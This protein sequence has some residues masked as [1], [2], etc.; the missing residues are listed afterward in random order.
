MYRRSE[1]L[2]ISISSFDSI[3]STCDSDHMNQSPSPENH[4]IHQPKLWMALHHPNAKASAGLPLLAA[5]VT[6][7]RMAQ[8]VAWCNEET[9]SGL[10]AV[11]Q[12]A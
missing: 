11:S 8:Q 10:R 2:Y 12:M 9:G 3:R 7:Q 1:Y 4:P 5:Q 6:H